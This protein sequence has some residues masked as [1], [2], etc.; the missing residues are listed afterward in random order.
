M[1]IAISVF[2]L[3]LF[4]AIV[5]SFRKPKEPKE[6]KEPNLSFLDYTSV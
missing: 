2:S 1:L 3:L 5:T 4:V 6:P